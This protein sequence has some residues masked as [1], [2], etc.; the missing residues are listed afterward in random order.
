MLGWSGSAA[1]STHVH[2]ADLCKSMVQALGNMTTPVAQATTVHNTTVHN[3]CI[4]VNESA[5]ASIDAVT[6]RG[7][8]RDYFHGASLAINPFP[9]EPVHFYTSD[10]EA[11][12]SDW[13]TTR[14]D[15]ER[16]WGTTVIIRNCLDRQIDG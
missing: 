1:T 6:F 10:R 14:S 3:M 11:L 5:H 4:S 9:A 2:S 12:L 8:L 7:A 13:I 16:V 15:L